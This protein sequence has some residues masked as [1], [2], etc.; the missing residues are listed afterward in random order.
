M[1]NKPSSHSCIKILLSWLLIILSTWLSIANFSLESAMLDIYTEYL[2]AMDSVELPKTTEKW[3]IFWQSYKAQHQ[4]SI[5]SSQQSIYEIQKSLRW[6][7]TTWCNQI[8]VSHIH[9]ILF[10]TNTAYRSSIQHNTQT[11]LKSPRV[12]DT[13]QTAHVAQSCVPIMQCLGR[14]NSYSLSATLVESCT[15][16][17]SEYYD[18]AQQY[19]RAYDRLQSVN[20]WVQWYSNGTL[21]DSSYDLMTDIEY[22]GDILFAN[23][24]K[25]TDI[26]YYQ[27]PK[28]SNTPTDTKTKKNTD[29][30]THPSQNKD[31]QPPFDSIDTPRT[32]VV[33]ISDPKKSP[34]NI[35]EDDI[36]D[37]LIQQTKP[38][39]I[40]S[41]ALPQDL[42]WPDRCL[43]DQ[44]T[45]PDD[46]TVTDKKIRKDYLT[47]I[48]QE[49]TSRI[50][51]DKDINQKIKDKQQQNNNNK[52]PN[53]LDRK[54]TEQENKELFNSCT[55]Q[56]KDLSFYDQVICMAECL[57][58]IWT[59][60]EE[61]EFIDLTIRFCMIPT[62]Q[63]EVLGDQKVKSI[64]EIIQKINTVLNALITSGEMGKH[65]HTTEFLDSSL[66]NIKLHELI[67]FNIAVGFKPV[68]DTIPDLIIKKDIEQ[69][70]KQQEQ[71][72]LYGDKSK[73]LAI[74][75]VSTT[76]PSSISYD[77]PIQKNQASIEILIHD[78]IQNNLIFWTEI[79]GIMEQIQE[80]TL[81]LRKKIEKG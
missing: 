12:R 35:R 65:N 67:A 79:G 43:I 66:Q 42:F 53:P 27:L 32:S 28:P 33:S 68:F 80:S 21:D 16:I 52:S 76:L 57:C 38:E 9:D 62:Q 71:H 10:G 58:D 77:N 59:P 72:Y 18:Q 25:N 20:E 69:K 64:E 40:K 15:T 30:H 81:G 13:D 6:L 50:P 23:N 44:P 11:I 46:K 73:Y 24:K 4:R 31:V 1:Y 55:N 2:A 45:P 19:S 41:S 39:S 22:I 60:L 61:S 5:S 49:N 29:T 7:A 78:F 54:N 51:V 48:D 36:I 63:S 8:E 17:V 34:T 3:D 75:K 26:L 47:N 56:C 74:E 14:T 70:N 37:G